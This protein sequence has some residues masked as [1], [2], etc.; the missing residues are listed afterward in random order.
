M[1][2]NIKAVKRSG[3]IAFDQTLDLPR[4]ARDVIDIAAI[5]PVHVVG[6]ATY[7]SPL[8]T[9]EGVVEARI[10][11]VCSRCLTNF[12]QDLSTHLL[13]SYTTDPQQVGEEIPCLTED[14]L[15]VSENIEEAIFLALD[16]RPLCRTDC[17]G[18]CADCGTNLN[19]H[20]CGCDTRPIDPRLAALKDLLSSEQSE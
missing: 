2:L 18:L 17:K 16:E 11:Y 13:Q 3:Q 12:E 20:T 15:D 7:T 9:I 6:T 5:S 1:L 19:E 8:L 14:E 4:V 10:T